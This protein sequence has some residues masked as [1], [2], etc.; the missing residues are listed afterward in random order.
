MKDRQFIGGQY[1]PQDPID[2]MVIQALEVIKRDTDM[3]N[4]DIVGL[5][6]IAMAEGKGYTRDAAMLP[7]VLEGRVTGL[8]ERLLQATESLVDIIEAKHHEDH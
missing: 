8:L 7:T 4:R 5:A 3:S 1:D 2:S 6:I